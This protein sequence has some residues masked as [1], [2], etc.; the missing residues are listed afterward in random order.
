[1]A[2]KD[3]IFTDNEISMSGLVD[4]EQ[5]LKS[6]AFNAKVASVFDDMVSRSVPG[7]ELVQNLIADFISKNASPNSNI[8]D[9]GCSTA[10][11]L[12]KIITKIK[13][14]TKIRDLSLIGIDSSSEMIKRAKEKV[15]ALGFNND[16][17]LQ[18]GD[19][20][21]TPIKNASFVISTYTIQFIEPKQ[22]LELLKKI[23]NGMNVNSYL[24]ISE[25]IHFKDD[26]IQSFLTEKYYDFKRTNGY[27]DIEIIRK[28]Q[29]LENVLITLTEEENISML[30]AAGFKHI[31][32][33]HS[34][35]V[36]KTFIAK[37]I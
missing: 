15:D 14:S 19:I 34:D 3:Q 4:S 13:L 23:F 12:I 24:F 21:K 9:L 10:T 33:I 2:N 26:P 36:F 20:I 11:T 18:V 32:V 30:K 22:R 28:R 27:S 37:K 31:D 17:E 6:F 25:K 8:Y 1:M 16:I 7:Y 35:L 5:N 29:A